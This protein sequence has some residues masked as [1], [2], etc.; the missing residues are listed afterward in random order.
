MDM[1]LSICLLIAGLV[2][3]FA[4]EAVAADDEALED[5]FV[6]GRNGYACYRIPSILRASNGDLLAF[7]EGRKK[8]CSDTGDIDLVM[9]R[10][11]DGGR[12]WGP[13]R[14]VW[15]D[16]GNTC[17]NPCPVVDRSTGTIHMWMTWNHGKDHE[18]RIKTGKSQYGG[19]KPY[20][21]V[22]TDDGQTW[23]KPR[24]MSEMVDRHGWGWY[25]TGPG[26]GIQ[27]RRGEHKGRLLIPANHSD[28]KKQYNAHAIFSDDGGQTWSISTS[29]A[30]GAN[31]SQVVER[32]DSTVLFN[33]RMQTHKKG[34]RGIATST[35]GGATWKDF[36]HDE[37][38][39]DPTCQASLV[40]FQRKGGPLLFANPATGGRKGMTVR[41]S[42]DGGRTWPHQK[43]IYAG[44]SA[45]SSLV[46]LD[47]ERIGLLF[48][49]DRY[50]KISFLRMRF[51]NGFEAIKP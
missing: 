4:Q 12:S 36:K 50:R 33:T 10:S 41:A 39:S 15:D 43:L 16:G 42:L 22:S 25:A 46:V 23:S 49:R 44:S 31:E 21:A 3:L 20:Y 8:S 24:D 14:K 5:L 34:K 19:R 27:L 13:V 45:Y 28:L 7:C 47:E 51:S 1:R 26:V 37:H 48:E 32:D 6:S 2:L 18:S 9:R 35:D 11:T 40:R 38:L 17:G 30:P 29:V